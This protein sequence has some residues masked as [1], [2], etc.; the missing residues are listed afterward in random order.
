MSQRAIIYARVSLDATGEGRSVARQLESCQSLADARSYT[1]VGTEHDS[2]SAYSDKKRPGW[3][4]VK[5]AAERHEVDVIVAW[6]LDRVT[7]SMAELEQVIDLAE[8]TGVGVATVSGEMDLTTSNGRMIAR[9]LGSVARAEVE[10]KATRQKAA[11]LQGAK[12]GRPFRAG[13]AL[14][15]YNAE[16]CLVQTEAD[17]IRQAAR[18]VLEGAS[19][20]SIMKRWN[21]AGLHPRSTRRTAVS[22]WTV[23]NCV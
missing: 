17:A 11:N 18:D 7:R 10:M 14:F 15:G 8:R 16:G 3:E 21:Q 19:V 9:I 20:Y 12:E 5:A 2:Q 22:V 1:V 13:P 23:T 6:Q 4:Q